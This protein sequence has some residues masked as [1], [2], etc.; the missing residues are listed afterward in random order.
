M[1]NHPAANEPFEEQPM[2]KQIFAKFSLIAATG[3]LLHA[4]GGAAD[5]V[6]SNLVSGAIGPHT[7]VLSYPFS[8]SI[9]N[10]TGGFYRRVGKVTVTDSEGNGIPGVTVN[11]KLI[12]SIIARGT[13]Q[14][15]EYISGGVISDSNPLDG[16][17]AA[18]AFNT[19]EVYRNGA[20][21]KIQFGD[22]VLLFNADEADKR[23][24][25]S[26]IAPI[27]NALYVNPSYVNIY[28]NTDYDS[29]T[30]E[31]TTS[32]I[33]GASL[34]GGSISG[35]S[36]TS[37][38]TTT[39]STGVGVFYITYPNSVSYIN[40]GCT[41]PAVIDDLR[42]LPADSAQIYVTA[43]VNDDVAVNSADFCFSPIAGGRFDPEITTVNAGDTIVY[44]V[45]DGGD[46]V[47]IPYT[48]VQSSGASV[49]L[50]NGGYT[51]ASGAIS[52]TFNI[53]GAVTL[54]ANG[55]ATLNI[56]VN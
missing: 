29:S 19:A 41:D 22:H 23:R 52:V 33:V 37:D 32:Y 31:K 3:I 13:I 2:T 43:W 50:S 38:R 1:D 39:D 7:I 25:V 54:S 20:I 17:G 8:D 36:G 27:A 45:R 5:S 48:R 21:R 26:N 42:H 47:R 53:A 24:Y 46:E 49:T 40:T 11:L 55:G 35:G 6:D 15:P 9:E 34:L 56:T 14:A 4:C 44:Y 10:L 28:P 51:D 12:D 16:G 18:T 30:P